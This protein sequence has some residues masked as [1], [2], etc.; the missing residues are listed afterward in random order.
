[1][2]KPFCEIRVDGLTMNLT[3]KE[4]SVRQTIFHPK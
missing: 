3:D 1:M 4:K 2:L